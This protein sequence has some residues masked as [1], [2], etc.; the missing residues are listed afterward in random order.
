MCVCVCVQ[1]KEG[2]NILLVMFCKLFHFYL[3][4]F[5]SAQCG[6]L[7]MSINFK[8]HP[9]PTPK[10]LEQLIHSLYVTVKTLASSTHGHSL[11]HEIS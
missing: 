8:S 10:K 2:R 4:T 6:T 5:G 1:T 9:L 7:D 11:R 3:S